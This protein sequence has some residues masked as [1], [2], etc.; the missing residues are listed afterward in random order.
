[1]PAPLFMGFIPYRIGSTLAGIKGL[2]NIA[3]PWLC[4]GDFNTV[5]YSD[6]IINGNPVTDYEVKD[7]KDC[8][9]TMELT[10]L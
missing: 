4:L 1:M 9:K 3:L 7:F 10:K 2:G 6:D 8:I 5:L